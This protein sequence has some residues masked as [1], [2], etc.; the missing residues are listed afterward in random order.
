MI[1]LKTVNNELRAFAFPTPG[2]E[3]TLEEKEW[4][5]YC[6]NNDNKIINGKFIPNHIDKRSYAEKRLAEYPSLGNMIDALCKAS[7]GEPAELQQLLSLR[8]TIK[9]KYP[10]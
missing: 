9:N 6:T 7:E 3:L 4:E 1:Y 2:F 8:Q 5:K 10:K